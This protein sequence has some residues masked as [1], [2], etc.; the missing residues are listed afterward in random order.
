MER[1]DKDKDGVITFEDFANEIITVPD[2][3]C[4][5]EDEIWS[6]RQFGRKQMGKYEE[7]R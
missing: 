7:M 1:Y 6:Y 3:D 2:S 4:V 5:K